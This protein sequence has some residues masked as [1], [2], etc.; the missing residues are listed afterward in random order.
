[1]FAVLVRSCVD[2]RMSIADSFDSC[3][4]Y[5]FPLSRDAFAFTFLLIQDI[6]TVFQNCISENASTMFNTSHAC[7]ACELHRS[8]LNIIRVDLLAMCCCFGG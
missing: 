2:T 7:F 8:P 6:I 3:L 5:F 1:M 4:D